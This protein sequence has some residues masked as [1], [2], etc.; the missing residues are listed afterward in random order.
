MLTVIEKEKKAN[1][2][3]PKFVQKVTLERP[4]CA[5]GHGERNRCS[6]CP[7]VAGS[8]VGKLHVK[9]MITQYLCNYKLRSEL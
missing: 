8:L 1:P 7:L 4:L 5:R 2:P 3:H 6:L 9:Q